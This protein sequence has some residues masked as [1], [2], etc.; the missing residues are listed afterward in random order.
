MN[1]IK[2]I[3]VVFKTTTDD[4]LYELFKQIKNDLVVAC[5]DSDIIDLMDQFGDILLYYKT[6]TNY[7]NKIIN[8][9]VDESIDPPKKLFTYNR[10][11]NKNLY[12]LF[13][14]LIDTNLEYMYSNFLELNKN[15]SEMEVKN[16]SEME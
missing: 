6:S 5:A 16:T 14:Y 10:D 4:K 12:G 8:G 2:Y 1:C 15:T 9:I 7:Y 11:N 13:K 3:G